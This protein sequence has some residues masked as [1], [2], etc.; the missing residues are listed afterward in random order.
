MDDIDRY[1]SLKANEDRIYD[2]YKEIKAEREA[3]RDKI[4]ADMDGKGIASMFG[5]SG[6]K[7]STTHTVI[8]RV[9]DMAMFKRW[10]EES[11]NVDK[12]L[13][14]VVNQTECSRMVKDYQERGILDQL[15]P[16]M[17]FISILGLRVTTPKNGNGFAAAGKSVIEMLKQQKG[18]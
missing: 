18:E 9:E 15:P 4:A 1:I 5:E 7:V 14:E 2:D 13:K 10:C 17:S 6:K 11:G 16:G 12:Y 3:L 8:A